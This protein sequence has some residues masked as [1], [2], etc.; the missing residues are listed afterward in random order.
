MMSAK[1]V[2]YAGIVARIRYLGTISVQHFGKR[3]DEFPLSLLFRA[4]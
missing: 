2:E 4:V 3:Q 1:I